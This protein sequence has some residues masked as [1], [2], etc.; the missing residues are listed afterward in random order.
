MVL[1]TSS[2]LLPGDFFNTSRNN[3]S[4][5][6]PGEYLAQQFES[7]N[8]V[9]KEYIKSLEKKLA[10]FPDSIQL[11]NELAVTY[12]YQNNIEEAEKH[13]QYLLAEDSTNFFAPNNLGNLYF[14]KGNLE[15]AQT[16]YFKALDYANGEDSAGV[17]LNLGLIYAAADLDSEAV[18][19]F[20][21]VMQDSND[22]QRI[23]DLLGIVIKEEELV[24]NAIPDSG[25]KISKAKV[26]YLTAKAKEK[27]KKKEKIKT[28]S[29]G[30][31]GK[32]P[33]KSKKSLKCKGR[34]NKDEIENVFY[35]RY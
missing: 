4:K 16:Y 10:Q 13:F 24:K 7:I 30:G 27:K 14:M 29:L 6:E 28:A 15:L 25:K 17:Y 19:I 31:T 11:R 33:I 8:D 21:Y 20:A 18:D 5:K 9:Q 3:D 1:I 26:K 12:V 23:G 35:W 32:S 34:I 2:S 22:Y